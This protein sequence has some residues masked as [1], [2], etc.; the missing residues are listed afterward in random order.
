MGYFAN[1]NE[2]NV[3]TR[4]IVCDSAKLCEELLGGRWVETD[5]NGNYA[6]KGFAYY[7]DEKVFTPPQPYP[8]W[9]LS[10]NKAKWDPPIPRPGPEEAY[11]WN[12]H[13]KVWVLREEP[14]TNKP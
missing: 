6:G 3:V 13:R 7:L 11:R 9:R 5:I 10:A 1:L 12:E 8:S 14:V 4:V 2:Q